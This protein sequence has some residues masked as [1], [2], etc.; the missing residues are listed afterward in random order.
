MS[1]KVDADETERMKERIA[2]K[3]AQLRKGMK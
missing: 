2:E 3:L 1:A